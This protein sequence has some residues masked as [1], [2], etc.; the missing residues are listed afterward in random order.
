MS[1]DASGRDM[2]EGICLISIGNLEQDILEYLKT[3][4]QEIFQTHLTL[5][6]TN[7]SVL[8]SSYNPKRRQFYSSKILDNLKRPTLADCPR[9][10]GI[11]D[12]DLYVPQLN[13]VFGEADINNKIAIISLARLRQEYYSLKRDDNIFKGRVLKEAVHELG[14]TFGLG[15]CQN[16]ACVMF[17]S[18]SLRDTDRKNF[19]FCSKCQKALLH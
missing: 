12:V 10:L 14:H 16:P 17:F 8:K 5:K 6:N 11:V 19:H 13:F 9:A 15:H 1:V 3:N 18:N 2:K 4:L 7:D